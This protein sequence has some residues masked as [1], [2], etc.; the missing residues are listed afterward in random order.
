M[1]VQGTV[2]GS[3]VTATSVIDQK[4]LVNNNS[5][6]MMDQNPKPQ[7]FMG[8]MMNG[9]GNFFKKLFGF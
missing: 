9:I 8:G 4:A 6:N 5:E 2:N 3:S 1:V 7:G